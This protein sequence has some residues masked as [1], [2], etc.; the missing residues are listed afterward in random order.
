MK[1]LLIPFVALLAL[2]SCSK[3]VPMTGEAGDQAVTFQVAG[4][5][6]GTKA[7]VSLAEEF[8][9]FHTYGIFHSTDPNADENQWF[10]RAEEGDDHGEEVVATGEYPNVT[11]WSPAHPYYWPKTG[12]VSFYSYAGTRY[13]VVFPQPGDE[14]PPAEEGNLD[15]GRY[16]FVFGDWSPNGVMPMSIRGIPEIVTEKPTGDDQGETAG[17]EILPADNILVADVAY[18]FQK[19]LNKYGVDPLTSTP[20]GVP[21]LFHHMLAKIR[22]QVVLDATDCKDENMTWTVKVRPSIPDIQDT[23]DTQVTPLLQVKNKAWLGVKY[24]DIEGHENEVNYVPSF[25]PDLDFMWMLDGDSVKQGFMNV[26]LE[27]TAKGG[28]EGGER[29]PSKNEKDETVLNNLI[30]VPLVNGDPVGLRELVVIPQQIINIPFN[31]QFDLT[32]TYTYPEDHPKAGDKETITET[33]T[34]SPVDPEEALGN[35]EVYDNQTTPHATMANIFYPGKHVQDDNLR[36]EPNH[37]YTYQ[38]VIKTNGEVTF[39]PAVV[40]WY[41]DNA[42]FTY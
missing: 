2:A 7:N 41:T 11:L 1:K 6:A 19:S 40:D 25:N 21:T 26:G 27:L 24:P 5:A 4:Y 31:F 12:N 37:I 8:N 42:E 38:I 17:Q 32:S 13:P 29:V 39:D 10:M 15:D 20:Y 23:Q 35:G 33:I 16:M 22:F 18:R 3:V 30:S 14:F 28:P 36:W 9:S 34:V